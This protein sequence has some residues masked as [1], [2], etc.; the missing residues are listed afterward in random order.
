MIDNRYL[1]IEKTKGGIA[2]AIKAYVRVSTKEQ[3]LAPQIKEIL[4]YANDRFKESIADENIFSDEAS[5][6]TTDNRPNLQKMLDSLQENDVLIIRE[7]SRLARSTKDLLNIVDTIKA[8]K[9]KLVS[10]KESIDTDG[11][12]GDC[13]IA[14]LGAVY[15]LEN[16]IR[17]ERQRAGIALAKEAGKYKKPKKKQPKFWKDVFQRWLN[18]QTSFERMAKECNVSKTTITKWVR[19]ER[20]KLKKATK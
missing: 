13:I 16:D 3:H 1:N 18:R 20:E 4:E 14:I 8:K 5:G 17:K 11:P 19:E 12:L 7:F 9:A 15:Q 2:M 6:T 10:I